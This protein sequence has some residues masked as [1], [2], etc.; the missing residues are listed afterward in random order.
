MPLRYMR[1]CGFIGEVLRNER[2]NQ[3]AFPVKELQDY[4]ANH[5]KYEERSTSQQAGSSGTASSSGITQT[6]DDWCEQ[7]KEAVDEAPPPPYTLE[8]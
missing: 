6:F 1:I 3:E 8:D 5:P 4:W 2:P 7:E